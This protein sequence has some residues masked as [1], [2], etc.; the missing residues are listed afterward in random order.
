MWEE[1][2]KAFSL[3]YLPS[4]FKFILG[5]L[6]GYAAGVHVVTAMVSTFAGMMTIVVVMVYS[7]NWFRERVMNR[8]FP[9]RRRFSERSR[10]LA[11][12]WRKYGL[13]GVALLT[14]LVL[15]PIGG[16]L[17]AVSFGGPRQ[18]ILLYMTVSA[19]VWSVVL[20]AAVYFFGQQLPD[21]QKWLL[22]LIG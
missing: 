3:S 2:L 18:K 17:V 13:A 1:L 7:G 10:R 12:I 20:N 22:G 11:M 19:A 21:I 16:A 4:M 6:G 14:P 9:A 8:L 15:T 5:P